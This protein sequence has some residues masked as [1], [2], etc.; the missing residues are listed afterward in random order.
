MKL[1]EINGKY[2]ITDFDEAEAYNI[3]C[4]LEKD[5]TGFY[6]YLAGKVEGQEAKKLFEF[7]IDQERK[8]FEVFKAQLDRLQQQEDMS[9]EPAENV[10]AMMDLGVI[11]PYHVLG[12]ISEGIDDMSKAF[13]L[14]ITMEDKSIKFYEACLQHVSSKQVKQ[15]LVGIINEE[16]KH[17]ELLE[18]AQKKD[19]GDFDG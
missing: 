11:P 12:K 16:K 9:K 14:A 15:D 5:G 1:E 17:K 18:S 8:H 13:S 7:L 2:V 10:L 19:K 3:A 4:K 6:V